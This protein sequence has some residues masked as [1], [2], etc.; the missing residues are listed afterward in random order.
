MT[1]RTDGVTYR[2]FVSYSSEDRGLVQ[3]IIEI[4]RANNLEPMWDE[5]FAVGKG[6]HE[7][8]KNFIAHSH[9]FLPVLTK[10]ADQRKWVHQ[11]IGYAMAL[12]IPVLPV[13]I[14]SLPGEMIDQIHAVSVTQD[15]VLQLSGRLT[16]DAVRALVDANGARNIALYTCADSPQ[17]RATAIAQH[18]EDVLSLGRF[19][20]VRQKGGLTSFH[21][22]KEMVQNRKW[23]ERYDP[24]AYNYEHCLAQRSE[25]RALTKHAAVE[26]C[27]LI[28]T[29]PAEAYTHLGQPARISRLRCL[30]EF[31]SEMDDEKCQ[32]ATSATDP[33]DNVLVVG[34]W[35]VAESVSMRR[36][37]RQT[38]LTRHAPTV[39][40]RVKDF[41]A[42]FNE[43]LEEAGVKPS[44]SRGRCVGLIDEEISNILNKPTT[45]TSTK[46]SA[47]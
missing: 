4:L 24:D 10:L 38:I 25:R 2:I 30:R 6:F 33:N 22:P 23:K 11:E 27:R 7:Q 34:N 31:L 26:G 36:K 44:E 32:V 45:D 37:Y 40:T 14:G 9:V 17:S 8:I 41:D 16:V 3:Q 46:D 29:P 21:L 18:C 19:G 42:E 1:V 20:K 43:S 28:I 12:N 39:A 5:D 35:F 47:R 13:A 15:T